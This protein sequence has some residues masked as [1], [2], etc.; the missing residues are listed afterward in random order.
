MA[1][2][3]IKLTESDLHNIIKESV[4]N[5]LTELDWRTYDSAANKLAK[6]EHPYES[7]YEKAYREKRERALRDASAKQYSKQYN[8]EDYDKNDDYT[9]TKIE[10]LYNDDTPKSYGTLRNL[11]KRQKDAN[12]YYSKKSRYQDGKWQNIYDK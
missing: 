5:L 12:D 11:V 9:S 8:L 6:Q 4:K 1:K 7:D 3:I 2:K 10:Q